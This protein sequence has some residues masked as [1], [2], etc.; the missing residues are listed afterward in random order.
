MKCTERYLLFALN[1]I[2]AEN[3][4]TPTAEKALS[5]HCI[6]RAIPWDLYASGHVIISIIL[7]ECFCEQLANCFRVN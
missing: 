4:L 3:D 7:T 6:R 5:E 1:R 2:G